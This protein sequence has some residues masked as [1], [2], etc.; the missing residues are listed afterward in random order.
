MEEINMELTN[1]L[2]EALMRRFDPDGKG[3]INYSEFVECI[4]PFVVTLSPIILSTFP[5]TRRITRSVS[6]GRKNDLD[7][8]YEDYLYRTVQKKRK[9]NLELWYDDYLIKAEKERIK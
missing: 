9:K 4:T 1:D 6:R 5:K 2:L 7:N 8:W 3:R